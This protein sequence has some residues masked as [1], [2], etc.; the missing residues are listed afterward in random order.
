MICPTAKAE[1]FLEGGW[2]GN[3]LICP[4]GSVLTAIELTLSSFVMARLVPA[5]HVFK[6]SHAP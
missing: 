2:T 1:N 5:I 4:S 3:S 6:A